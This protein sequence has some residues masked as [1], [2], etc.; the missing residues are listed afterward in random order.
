VPDRPYRQPQ[1][2]SITCRAV[3]PWTQYRSVPLLETGLYDFPASYLVPV[4]RAALQQASVRWSDLT[5]EATRACSLVGW[6]SQDSDSCSWLLGR[7]VFCL[8]M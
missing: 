2:F 1:P 5:V 4:F 8:E 7:D 3:A 6:D